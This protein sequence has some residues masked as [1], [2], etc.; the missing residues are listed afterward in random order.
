V[1]L[2]LARQRLVVHSA[3]GAAVHDERHEW[4]ENR[5]VRQKSGSEGGRCEGEAGNSEK[6]GAAPQARVRVRSGSK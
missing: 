1:S 2:Q 3:V 5:A 6:A 4:W